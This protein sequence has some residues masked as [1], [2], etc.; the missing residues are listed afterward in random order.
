MDQIVRPSHFC[1]FCAFLKK[2]K[3]QGNLVDA[4]TNQVTPQAWFSFGHAPPN[5]CCFLAPDWS[6]IVTAQP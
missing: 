2:K 1:G 4:F 6:S 3:A 5:L